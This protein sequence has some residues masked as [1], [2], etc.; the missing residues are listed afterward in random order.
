MKVRIRDIRSEGLEMI[1]Q[2]EAA[3]L[4]F[5]VQYDFNFIEPLTI[6]AKFQRAG[7]TILVDTLVKSQYESLCARCLEPTQGN[8]EKHFTFDFAADPTIEFVEI[9]DD[10]RQELFLNLPTRLL[11]QKDCKGLCIK[12]GVN[13]NNEQCKCLHK[14]S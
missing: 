13:L 11:C 9:N 3:T 6:K 4:G 2:V 1:E 5:E 7:Q 10:I 8:W 12:C 14:E